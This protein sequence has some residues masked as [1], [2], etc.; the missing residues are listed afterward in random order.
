MKHVIDTTARLTNALGSYL[1]KLPLAPT[2]KITDAEIVTI[3]NE[4]IDRR[5]YFGEGMINKY[6]RVCTN[7]DVIA[8]I[9]SIPHELIVVDPLVIS[10]QKKHV[11]QEVVHDDDKPFNIQVSEKLIQL[12]RSAKN[13]NLE[14]N[15]TIGDVSKLLKRKTCYYTGMKLKRYTYTDDM[16]SRTIDGLTIDRI[17]SSLGYVKGNVVACSHFANLMKERLFEK[18]EH[19]FENKA[20]YLIRMMK[21]IEKLQKEK[22]LC[23]K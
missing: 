12:Y 21:V 6:L 16:T 8:A 11:K 23:L 17:D 7:T 2:G 3:I 10:V 9:K 1:K 19:L 22:K 15:L 5:F 20:N 13:R 4:S 14:F 18:E